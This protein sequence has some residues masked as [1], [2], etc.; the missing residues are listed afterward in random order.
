MMWGNGYGGGF[1]WW[2]MGGEALVAALLI[3]GIVFAVLLATRRAEPSQISGGTNARAI[4]EARLARGE[5]DEEEFQRRSSL[6]SH[7]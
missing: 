2:M 4:L 6:L 1:S 5:I 3:A 7:S